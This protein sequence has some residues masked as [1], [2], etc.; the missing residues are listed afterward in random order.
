MD[1]QEKDTTR[2]PLATDTRFIEL[3]RTGELEYWLKVLDTTYEELLAAISEVGA[4]ASAV[5][6]QLKAKKGR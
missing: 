1:Q 6:R 3:E 4:S 2:P 5:A